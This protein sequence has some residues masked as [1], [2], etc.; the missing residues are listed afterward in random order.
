MPRKMARQTLERHAGAC[1]AGSRLPR[2]GTSRIQKIATI[3]T[4][5]EFIR[6][7]PVEGRTLTL[8]EMPPTARP[9]PRGMANVSGRV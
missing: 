4:T 1:Y 5:S 9:G 2:V 6:G 7:I 3:C 8:G